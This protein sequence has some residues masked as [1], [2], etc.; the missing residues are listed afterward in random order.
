MCRSALYVSRNNPYSAA[1]IMPSVTLGPAHCVWVISRS[2]AGQFCT[3]GSSSAWDSYG[4]LV[5]TATSGARP[6]AAATAISVQVTHFCQWS[7]SSGTAERM[8][9]TV[10]SF[11]GAK[12]SES[13]RLDC[14]RTRQRELANNSTLII[15]SAAVMPFIGLATSSH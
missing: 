7:C 9:L 12:G 8:Q 10:Q 3:W 4:G 15:E 13:S 6:S 5:A 14:S 11:M 2:V 1:F